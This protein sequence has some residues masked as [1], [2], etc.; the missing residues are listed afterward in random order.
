M[1]ESLTKSATSFSNNSLTLAILWKTTAHSI[2]WELATDTTS[3]LPLTPTREMTQYTPIQ[4]STK[5]ILPSSLSGPSRH[6]S[7]FSCKK[8]PKHVVVPQARVGWPYTF[9][10]VNRWYANHGIILHLITYYDL[11]I[12]LWQL[13]IKT[14]FGRRQCHECDG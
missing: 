5:K 7:L 3:T 11:T 6:L 9:I 14:P 2:H 4:A 10:M 13:M 8:H 12:L 1:T